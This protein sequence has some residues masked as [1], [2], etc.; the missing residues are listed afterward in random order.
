MLNKKAEKNST[1]KLFKKTGNE[2][3]ETSFQEKII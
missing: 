1:K 2:P 3:T